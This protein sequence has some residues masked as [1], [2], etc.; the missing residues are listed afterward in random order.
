MPVP[1]VRPFTVGPTM[2]AILSFVTTELANVAVSVPVEAGAVTSPTM[3]MAWSPLFVLERLD[4]L[5]VPE[6]TIDVGVIAPKLKL[7]VPFDVI[8]APDTLIPLAP[9]TLTLVTVP[10]PAMARICATVARLLADVLPS[11]MTV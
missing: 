2:S 9:D 10:A 5:I 3:V 6:A 7:T 1:D 11:T 4:P 8:G